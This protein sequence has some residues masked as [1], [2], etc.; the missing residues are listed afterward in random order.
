LDADDRLLPEALEAGLKC[1]KANP[2]CAFASGRYRFVAEDGSLLRQPRERVVEK[3]SYVALLQRNYIGPP[4]VVVYQRDV[5]D[6]VGSF[7]DSLRGC[8]DYDTYL[9]IAERF[10]ICSHEVVVAEYRRHGA[11]ASSNHA[12]IL[13]TSMIV[14]RKQRKH[15]KG[16]N[17]YQQA[18]TAGVKHSARGVRGSVGRA[19]A[20]SPARA[21]VEEGV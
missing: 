12:L 19:G 5:L 17:L 2:G 7:D 20:N 4:P 13:S 14:L 6:S 11:S 8:E 15:V 9:R 10:P 3:N 21:R 16:N 18:Y 1:L